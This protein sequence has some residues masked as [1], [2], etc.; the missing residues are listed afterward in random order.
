MKLIGRKKEKE[1]FEHCLN[2]TESKL[3]AVYGRRRVG[4]TFLVR[5]Y[6]DSKILFEVAGLHK[7]EMADQLRHFTSTLAKHG[8]TEAA[9]HEVRSWQMAFDMLERFIENK[10][11][12]QKKVIFIDELPWFDTPRSKFLTAFQNFWNSFCSKRSDV[13]CVICGSAASWMIKKILKN[14]GGLHNRVSERIRLSQFNLNEVDQFLKEK[15]IKWSQY[16]IAQLYLTTGGIPYYLDAVR[17]GESVVQFVNR[18][19]FSKDGILADEYNVLFSSLFSKSERHYEVV[20]ALNTK[21]SGLT[22]NELIA[23]TNLP[24]GGTLTN[25]LNE[26]EESGFIEEVVPY[27]QLKKKA[28]FKLVD[29]FT[30]F[31]LKF[32]SSTNKKGNRNWG[33]LVKSQSWISWS[34]LAYERLCFAHLPQIKKALKLEVIDCTFSTWSTN[35]ET[36]GAQ[37]DMLIDRADRIIN[38]CEIKFSNASFTIDKGYAK[39]LRNKLQV[40]SDYPSNKNKS[41]FLTMITTFGLNSNEYEKELVQSVIE[42]EDLFALI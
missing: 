17:K 40:V 11:G 21:K 27:Q 20:R 38:L 4:K 26:L 29:N 7:G 36:K 30:I 28:L 3:I 12:K 22:R 5:K 34:G 24:S 42:L 19:C 14:K 15:G 16:D 18:T 37:I 23:K 9:V 8:W 41:V 33:N 35:S 25:V 31:Y 10:K 6:F 1:T 39:K 32:M 2:S 13:V